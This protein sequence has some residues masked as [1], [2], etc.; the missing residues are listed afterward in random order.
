MVAGDYLFKKMSI[1]CDYIVDIQT[2]LQLL[3]LMF[4]HGCRWLFIVYSTKKLFILNDY[5]VDIHVQTWLQLIIYKLISTLQTTV[6][7]EYFYRPSLGVLQNLMTSVLYWHN[8]K[9][10][11]EP[12]EK[13]K[14]ILSIFNDESTESFICPRRHMSHVNKLQPVR[15]KMICIAAI[16]VTCMKDFVSVVKILLK[17]FF[18]CSLFPYPPQSALHAPQPIALPPTPSCNKRDTTYSY[19]TCSKVNAKSSRTSS[20]V[21][22]WR[23]GAQGHTIM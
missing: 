5:I 9:C 3:K 12:R 1:G 19:V 11:V 13:E 18:F 15:I 4:K 10:L 21:M 7:T 22:I 6:F 14:R 23:Y 2:W 16:R 20:D 8:P 17:T